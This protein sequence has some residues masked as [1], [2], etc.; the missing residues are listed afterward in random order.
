MKSSITG[1]H[2]TYSLI[3][4]PEAHRLVV[5]VYLTPK[6]PTNSKQT[7]IGRTVIPNSMVTVLQQNNKLTAWVT[8]AVEALVE[9]FE[10]S[11][12]DVGSPATDAEMS[13]HLSA[14]GFDVSPQMPT[15]SYDHAI[16]NKSAA[17]TKAITEGTPKA[18]A[19][20][21][22]LAAMKQSFKSSA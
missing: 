2:Y 11:L 19:I 21:A 14:L 1:E 9:D 3:N 20:A 4:E 13:G 7:E 18:K 15:G 16:A 22:E 6:N 17:L 10:V 8:D 5:V 12:N